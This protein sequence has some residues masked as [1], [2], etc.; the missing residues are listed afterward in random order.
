VRF[1]GFALLPTSCA[2]RHILTWWCRVGQV[3]G[4][5]VLNPDR[6]SRFVGRNDTGATSATARFHYERYPLS[7]VTTLQPN[8]TP[9]FGH[10]RDGRT[11]ETGTSRCR[12]DSFATLS[13]TRVGRSSVAWKI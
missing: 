5:A 1:V 11:R 4:G 13:S 7:P 12:G 8:S 3:Q 2:G 9:V 6:S 10:A